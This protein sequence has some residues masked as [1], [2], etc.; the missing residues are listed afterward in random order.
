MYRCVHNVDVYIRCM[1]IDNYVFIVHCVYWVYV[2]VFCTLSSVQSVNT[3]CPFF[4]FFALPPDKHTQG[5]WPRRKLCQHALSP[6]PL[7]QCRN[8]PPQHAWMTTVPYHSHWMLWSA[9]GDWSWNT[10]RNAS[11]QYWTHTNL[12][13][14]ALGAL[15]MQYAQYC[16]RYSHI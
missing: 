4:F 16:T 15:R 3:Y 6:H 9:L 5:C 10:L 7:C 12:P 11:H 8:T 1:C 13:T 2:C 14:K